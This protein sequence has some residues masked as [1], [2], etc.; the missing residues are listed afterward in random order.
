MPAISRF[1]GITIGMWFNEHGVP[2]F[3]AEY[4]EYEASFSIESGAPIAGADMPNRAKRMIEEW[5]KLHQ[6][7]LLDNWDAARNRRAL[8]RI[9]PLP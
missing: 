2:H 5:A 6:R 7:E 3:H 8:R 9:D 4:A 1:Y